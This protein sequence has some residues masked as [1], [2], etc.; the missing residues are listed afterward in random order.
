MFCQA[1]TSRTNVILSGMRRSRHWVERTASS[2]QKTKGFADKAISTHKTVDAD[3]GPIETR[4]YTAIHD[5]AWLQ[6]RHKWPGLKG[7]LMVTS[8]RGTGT[9]TERETR[10]YI[11]SLTLEA[12]LSESDSQCFG[13]NSCT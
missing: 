3:H 6:E 1:A 7:L 13:M 8:Q 11:T 9:R 12:K 4:V 2:E 10:L 5:V